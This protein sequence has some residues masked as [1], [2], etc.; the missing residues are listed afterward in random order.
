MPLSPETKELVQ[1][2]IDGLE[3]TFRNA[4]ELYD[5]AVLLT[6]MGAVARALLLHQIS[7]EECGKADML[8]AAVFSLLRGEEID[9]KRLTRAFSRHEAKNKANAYFLSRSVSELEAE[10]RND[11]AAAR[12]AFKDLQSKFHQE[13]NKL[14]NASLYVDFDGKFISP[15]DV[16]NDEHLADI[17]QRNAEFMAMAHHKVSVLTRWKADLDVAANE[18]A[19]M[20]MALGIDTLDKNDPKTLKDFMDSLP[21]KLEKLMA[22]H[23]TP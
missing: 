19:Q 20:S 11:T 23:K 7:L 5:E 12:E 2:L 10:E 21:G 8:C 3:M 16:I 13:S 9:M 6:G 1:T 22:Q 4:D 15:R 18:V 14:K 17:R